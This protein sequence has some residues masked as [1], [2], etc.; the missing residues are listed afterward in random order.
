MNPI[1]EAKYE[2]IKE[3]VAKTICHAEDFLE[4]SDPQT[5][6]RLRN[7]AINVKNVMTQIYENLSRED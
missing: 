2:Q 1:L 7:R 4:K 5:Q 3:A 6:R